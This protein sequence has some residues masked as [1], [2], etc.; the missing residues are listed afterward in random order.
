[1]K[2][3]IVREG[4][5]KSDSRVPLTPKQ[6]RYLLD[7]YRDLQIFVQPSQGRCFTDSEYQSQSIPL[8]ENLAECEILLGVKE[9]PI[10][11]L[12]PNK[13]ISFSLIRLK[14]NPI[15]GNYYVQFCK[16]KFA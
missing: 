11:L 1:M 3:G 4:K 16:K 8:T 14:N 7:K 9:V 6:C 12:L 2:V 5:I 10:N 15:I 13:P